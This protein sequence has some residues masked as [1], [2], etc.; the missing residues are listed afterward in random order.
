MQVRPWLNL[1][2]KEFMVVQQVPVQL[3]GC[4]AGASTALWLCSRCQYS[5]MVVQQVASTALFICAGLCVLHAS[6]SLCGF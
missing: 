2:D 1:A 4:A 3:Y 6:W 5:F